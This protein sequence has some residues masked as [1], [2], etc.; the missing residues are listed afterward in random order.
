MHDG[1]LGK[2]EIAGQGVGSHSRSQFAQRGHA[3]WPRTV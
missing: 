2:Q 1:S 3:H